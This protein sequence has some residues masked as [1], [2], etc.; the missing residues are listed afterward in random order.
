MKALILNSG[1]G[2]RLMPLTKDKPKCM[3]QLINNDTILSLQLKYIS[4]CGIKDVVIT[5]GYEAEKLVDYGSKLGSQSGISVTF[6]FN[7]LYESTN[8]IY[9]IYLAEEYLHDDL[10]LLH[11]DLVFDSAILKGLLQTSGSSMVVSSTATLPEK[12]FKAQIIGNRVTSIGI[13][14]FEKAMAAQPLYKLHLH[15][16]EIWLKRIVKFCEEGNRNC[17]AENAFNEVSDSC[18]LFPYDIKDLFCMEIDN[19]ADYEHAKQVLRY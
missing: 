12:D 15:D 6:V 10:V 11:G 13:D 18:E 4:L 8:Y 17:Y 9:S 2:S 16:W 19:K 3:T 14:I 7:N 1:F 5:T